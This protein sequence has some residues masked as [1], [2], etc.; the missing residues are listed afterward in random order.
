M[1]KRLNAKFSH[2]GLILKAGREKADLS[3]VAVAKKLG[4][5]S[6][7]F[8]SNFERG[9]SSPPTK[10]L[11]VLA[12]LYHLPVDELLQAIVL[13]QQKILQQSIHEMRKILVGR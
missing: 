11:K 7:Q 8:I 10:K 3:Q 4:Y 9:I 6:P 5:G 12:S 13:D 1:K 2:L